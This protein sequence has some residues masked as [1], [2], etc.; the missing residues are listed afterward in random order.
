MCNFGVQLKRQNHQIKKRLRVMTNR[1][2]ALEKKYAKACVS[3]LNKLLDKG[4]VTANQLPQ[5]FKDHGVPSDF[6][7][8]Q[9]F[10]FVNTTRGGSYIVCH[11]DLEYVQRMIELNIRNYE[12]AIRYCSGEDVKM[13]DGSAYDHRLS[14]YWMKH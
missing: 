5:L 11:G 9:I 10:R 13:P 1:E 6:D 4:R 14:L 12:M 2:K 3:M 8:G 7:S